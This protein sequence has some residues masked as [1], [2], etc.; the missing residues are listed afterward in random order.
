MSHE[1]L[2]RH[3]QRQIKVARWCAKLPL[4]W[5]YRVM[6]ILLPQLGGMHSLSINDEKNIFTRWYQKHHG[7]DLKR[8][9]Q[10]WHAVI[11]SHAAYLINACFHA[12]GINQ[13]AA[14]VKHQSTSWR[15]MLDEPEGALVL[16][17]HHDF[18]H[19]LFAMTG[20]ANRPV[21][22]LAAPE[23][24][25]P[26][27]PWIAKEI[28]QY[29]R[30]CAIH[31]CGGD[32]LFLDQQ[33]ASIVAVKKAFTQNHWLFALL[34]VG[35]ALGARSADTVLFGHTLTVPSGALDLAIKLRK[36]IYFTA[37]IW[38]PDTRSYVLH[39]EKI[40]HE[41][42]NA[43]NLYMRAIERLVNQYP[44]LWKGWQYLEHFP[45]ANTYLD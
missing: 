28:H 24:S 22:V 25:S 9:N 2:A 7:S 1:L 16:T 36:P 30:D 12:K 5:A 33:Y 20:R 38:Q 15:D 35:A 21:S 17:M 26:L 19:T 18:H 11:Q 34:D 40:A 41:D 45:S 8:I 23:E 6:T 10:A 14:L 39:A 32:Y 43:M 42:G 4:Q 29:H 13:I 31:F 3:L 37:M 27:A 44:W